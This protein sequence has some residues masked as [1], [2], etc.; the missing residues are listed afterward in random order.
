MIDSLGKYGPKP[1]VP[2][3]CFIILTVDNTGIYQNK[4]E[5]VFYTNKISLKLVF[6]PHIEEKK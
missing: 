4:K 5:N 6:V 1:W 3:E 2:I